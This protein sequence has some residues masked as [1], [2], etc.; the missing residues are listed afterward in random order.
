MEGW[1]VVGM[2]ERGRAMK[3]GKGK[4][5]GRRKRKENHIVNEPEIAEY[6]Q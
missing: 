3:G 6:L 5:E 4:G 2:F 1:K